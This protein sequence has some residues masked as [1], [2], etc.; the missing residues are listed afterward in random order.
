MEM[1]TEKMYMNPHTRSVDTLAGWAPHTP[2][3]AELIEVVKAYT[4]FTAAAKERVIAEYADL[5]KYAR[6]DLQE[7]VILQ[8]IFDRLTEKG[9]MDGKAYYE[10]SSFDSKT[11]HPAEIIVEESDLDFEWAEA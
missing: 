8:E 6:K 3:S 4:C 7:K 1:E 2:A 5:S 11:G 10:V 9:F